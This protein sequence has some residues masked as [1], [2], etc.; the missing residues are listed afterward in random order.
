VTTDEDHRDEADDNQVLNRD[1]L[2]DP[3]DAGRDDED[4]PGNNSEHG[5]DLSEV[6]SQLPTEEG[7]MQAIEYEV[8]QR[9]WVKDMDTALAVKKR[10][11]PDAVAHD[12]V[13]GI[14]QR[15]RK[16]G[17]GVEVTVERVVSD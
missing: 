3:A 1:G 4:D 15:L 12:M 2:V 16:E 11:L 10:L 14:R 13:I 17:G 8:I 9:T 7:C 5:S 6:A